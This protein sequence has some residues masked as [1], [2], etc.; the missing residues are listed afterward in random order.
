M[1]FS[2]YQKSFLSTQ[3]FLNDFYTEHLDNSDLFL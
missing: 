2:G 1:K 3:V